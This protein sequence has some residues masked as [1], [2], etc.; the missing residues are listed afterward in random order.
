M[1]ELDLGMNL[2]EFNKQGMNQFDPIDPILLHTEIEDM[3][4][5]ML[6]ATLNTKYWMLLCHERRD[7]T[8]INLIEPKL[9]TLTND[10]KETLTNRGQV[11][12]IDKLDDDSF[13]IWIR[14]FDTKENFVYYLFDYTYGVIEEV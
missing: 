13:E 10:V 14:D 9:D 3:A 6:F 8:I 12:S 4:K 1:A 7:Y 11:L 5:E 2:Y